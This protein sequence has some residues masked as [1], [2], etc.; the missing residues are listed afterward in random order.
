MQFVKVAF[1]FQNI[2]SVTMKTKHYRLTNTKY[3]ISKKKMHMGKSLKQQHALPY[4]IKHGTKQ[5]T[6]RNEISTGTGI[7]IPVKASREQITWK[8]VLTKCLT[9]QIHTTV[10]FFSSHLLPS[11]TFLTNILER[12]QRPM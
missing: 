11:S 7:Q 9:V 1:R 6:R 4:L 2:V 10:C 8:V 12:W 5:M 3:T